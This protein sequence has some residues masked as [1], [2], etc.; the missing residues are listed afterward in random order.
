MNWPKVSIILPCKNS[1]EFLDRVIINLIEQTYENKEI[2]IVDNFSSDST[3]R[4]VKRWQEKFDNIKFYQIG[5]ERATQMNYGIDKSEGE[6]I[7]LTGS[8]MLRDSDYVEQGVKKLQEDYHAIYASVLTDWRIEHYW[9]K[10]KA[11]ERL[12][13]IGSKYE[14]ARM[15]YK[16]VWYVR[17]KFDTNLVGIEEDFQH[18]L[19]RY[20]YKTGRIDAREYHLHEEDTLKK[21]YLKYFYYGRF[22]QYY[23]KKHKRR[24]RRFLNPFRDCFFKNWKLFL[25][26][27]GLA[28]GFI[29]YKIIQYTAG[30]L[31]MM[32]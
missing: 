7:Y 8:D 16:N 15:F 21:V 28:I 29:I 26:Y 30:I 24:G 4:I 6:I 25:R 22:A 14:S 31:G 2:V 5:P 3:P 10:V 20:G 1:E 17:G 23:L 12:C 27:P 19:D 18:R 32:R 11:L 9:G 13:Y